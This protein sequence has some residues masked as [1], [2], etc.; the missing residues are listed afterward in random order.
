[1]N[2]LPRNISYPKN[3]IKILLLENV[4]PAAFENLS[5]DG[6]EAYPNP[7]SNELTVVSEDDINLMK[8]YDITGK[9]ITSR[10]VNAKQTQVDVS[11]Y[12][13]GIYMISIETDDEV[14]TKKFIKQ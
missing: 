3:R 13:P 9:V 5:E 10:N 4:H 6:F 8:V 2:D 12:Q 11:T 14:I 1:M 7:A